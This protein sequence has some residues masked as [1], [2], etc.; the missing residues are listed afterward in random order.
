MV[1]QVIILSEVS[2]GYSSIGHQ[3]PPAKLKKARNEQRSEIQNQ[4][5]D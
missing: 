3:A 2:L 1:K 4:D 5:S